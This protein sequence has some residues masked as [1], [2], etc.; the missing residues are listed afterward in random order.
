M[1]V[2]YIY[3]ASC[4]IE[5]E[6]P[7]IR[8]QLTEKRNG[9][10][11]IL[12][13]KYTIN[14][15]QT[16]LKSNEDPNTVIEDLIKIDKETPF[17]RNLIEIKNI[18]STI[19]DENGQVGEKIIL[20]VRDKETQNI[21]GV[22]ALTFDYFDPNGERTMTND[23]MFIHYL[24][25]PFGGGFGKTLLHICIEMGKK[26]KTKQINLL[27]TFTA[28]PFYKHF[29][30]QHTTKAEEKEYNKAVKTSPRSA[31][32]S[33]SSSRR[34]TIFSRL[35]S[36]CRRRRKKSHAP[37]TYNLIYTYQIA[38]SKDTRIG[39]QRFYKNKTQ[40]QLS[41]SWKTS[42]SKEELK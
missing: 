14:N 35:F 10:V 41:K 19:Q 38:Q 3:D 42:Y 34:C 4:Q 22:L 2:F 25:T 30:F 33:S 6:D 23:N 32:P 31:N 39:G 27:S 36:S 16:K 11:S 15:E 26:A 7:N 40:K 21:S 24:C 17:C 9:I 28:V 20:Y 18:I 1:E 12:K 8:Q 29:G 13:K 5:T 37:S